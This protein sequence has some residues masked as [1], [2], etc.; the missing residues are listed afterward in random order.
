[1]SYLLRE[2]LLGA[3]GIESDLKWGTSH[4]ELSAIDLQLIPPSAGALIARITDLG[5]IYKFLEETTQEQQL[6]PYCQA[7]YDSIE[8]YLDQYRSTILKADED[9]NSGLLTTLTGLVAYVEPFQ[10][11]LQFVGRILPPLITASPLEKLNKMH[12]YVIVSPPS[13]AAKLSSFEHALQQVTISQLNSFLFYHQ[14]LPDIFETTK[15]G[16]IS[17]YNNLSVTFLPRQ[18]AEL[19]LLIVNVSSH[20]PDLFNETNPP[21]YNQLTQWTAS[22]ARTTST[23]LAS[24]LREQ[25]PSF[26]VILSSLILIGRSDYLS[27]LARKA[28]QPFVSSYDLNTVVSKFE[29]KFDVTLELSPRGISIIPKLSPPLD[30][31]VTPDHVKLLSEM[32]RIFMKLY[33]AVESLKDLWIS[34]KRFPQIY[35]FVGF[36]LELISVFT[37]HIIFVVISP[38]LV[39]LLKAASDIK[40]FLRFQ[41]E[42]SA[43]IIKLSTSF[44][45]L[46]PE[47]QVA[48]N[49]LSDKVIQTRELLIGK[50]KLEKATLKQMQEII[51]EVGADINAGAKKICTILSGNDETG[52]NLTDRLEKLMRC[53]KATSM[54]GAE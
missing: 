31:I 20:C 15:D 26:S 38:A 9:I 27:I 4:G 30:L 19:L 28:L 36:T 2:V 49:E 46:N 50:E 11:E 54:K 22:M 48:I 6:N 45:A 1:M 52:V 14:Q 21:E 13:V 41:G 44:P 51:R 7:L 47:F 8:N 18:L 34:T 10:H 39:Q 29:T 37:E 17:Y 12:E 23:L 42:F 32:F 40:D 35:T 16:R 25:W 53:I 43:F 33:V 5:A 3:L 24:N